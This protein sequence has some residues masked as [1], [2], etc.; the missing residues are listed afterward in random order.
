MRKSTRRLMALTLIAAL[1]LIPLSVALAKGPPVKVVI[2]GP[3]LDGD[4]TIT[5]PTLLDHFGSGQFESVRNRSHSAR[6]PFEK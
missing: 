6:K 3:G 4:I 5:D 2:S 1:A